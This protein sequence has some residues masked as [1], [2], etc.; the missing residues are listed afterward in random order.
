[1]PHR[2]LQGLGIEFPQDYTL[3]ET[4]LTPEGAGGFSTSRKQILYAPNN[5]ILIAQKCDKQRG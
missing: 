3:K 2:I 1:L 4:W 5:P